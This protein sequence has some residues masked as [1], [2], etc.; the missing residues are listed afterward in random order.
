MEFDTNGTDSV[1]WCCGYVPFSSKGSLTGGTG[2]LTTGGGG[3]FGLIF[4]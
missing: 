3:V 2:L 1:L 4:C